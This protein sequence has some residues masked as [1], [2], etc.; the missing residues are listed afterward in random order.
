MFYEY[1]IGDKQHGHIISRAE[2][3]EQLE[4]NNNLIRTYRNHNLKM[5]SMKKVVPVPCKKCWACRLNYSAEWATRIMNEAQGDPNCWFITLTYD[6]MNVPINESME[7]DKYDKNGNKTHK[8]IYNDGTWKYTL[9]PDDPNRFIKSLR[10][11]F[12][13]KG[14]HGIKYFYCGEYGETTERPHYHFILMHCPIN[15]L[16]FYGAHIDKNYKAHWKSQELERF[17]SKGL[18][19]IAELE[20]S[21][22]AYVARY[23]TKKI[24]D[25]YGKEPM[26]ETGR[27]HEFVKMSNNIGRKYY[28]SHKLDIYKN[29]EMIMKTVKGNIGSFKPPKAYDRLL[30]KENPELFRKIEISRQHEINRRKEIEEQLSD[31][32][33]KQKLEMKAEHIKQKAQLLPRTAIE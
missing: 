7:W 21:A 10:K 25:Q 20:W 16:E 23:C 3:R 12:E 32:T 33:D 2:A 17:W 6:N 22:A 15:P 29:D 11:Y 31:Y 28:E 5:D 1:N 4:H 9:D 19:D 8:K 13:R 27:W 26:W 14:Y 24:V 18:I 30:K